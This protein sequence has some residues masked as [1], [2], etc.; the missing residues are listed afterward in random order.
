MHSDAIKPGQ[1]IR[2]LRQQKGLSQADLAKHLGVSKSLVSMVE[3]GTRRLSQEEADA[4]ASLLELPEDLIRLSMGHLPDDVERTLPQHA[5]LVTTAVRQAAEEYATR[6]GDGLDAKWRQRCVTTTEPRPEPLSAGFEGTIR[7]GKNST[8]YRAH[9][10]HTKVPP[11][12][13]VPLIE[14]YTSPG[15]IVLDPFGGSGMTGVAALRAGRHALLSDVSPAAVHISRNYVTPCDPAL[16][17]EA[18]ERLYRAVRST[19]NSLY[20]VVGSDG[21]RMTVEH[22]VWSDVYQCPSCREQWTFWEATA[23]EIGR[24]AAREIPCPRCR[25]GHAKR[26]LVWVREEPV[27]TSTSGVTGRKQDKH[28]PTAAELKL[29]AKAAAMPI[30]YWTPR[31]DF[32]RDR[33]M[34][35]ASHGVMGIRTVSDFYTPRNLHALAALRHFILQEPDVRLRDALLFA[36]TGCVNRASRRYQWNEKRPTNVMTGTLYISSLRYE[37]NVWSLFS[38]KLADVTRY[39]AGFPRTEAQ[40]EV[41]MASAT[42]L[43][44]VPDS[45]VDFVFMDPP[46]GS[47]IFYADS[48]LLWEG[49]LGR[50]TSLTD[51]IVVNQHV[52]TA[53]GG[54]TVT[55]Y[56][57]LLRQSFSEVHRVLKP[58]AR[59]VLAF[60]N[61][62]DKVWEAIR[63]AVEAAGFEVENAAVL[64][65][66]QHSIKG[67]QGSLGNERVTRLDLLLTLRGRVAETQRQ[68][69][70][71]PTRSQIV[72]LTT[73]C[74][75][76][77]APASV[78]TDH[79]YT[80]VVQTLLKDGASV[81]GVGMSEVEAALAEVAT[82]SRDGQWRRVRHTPAEPPT[83]G[84]PGS[85]Q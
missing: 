40:A 62:D 66:V 4:L 47:N 46:F 76:Q 34:W 79:V 63:I 31:A 60:S 51:E 45:S 48:S 83:G 70:P 61:T 71:A 84:G 85:L 55:R 7:A 20:D 39:Y 82:R 5:A 77:A 35:R 28:E 59:A 57:D 21:S 11:E 42:N 54:K 30:P 8:T 12:A 29:I 78:A 44:H 3:N 43:G 69:S 26:D 25:V 38:R 14:H 74:L 15:D 32:G 36:F 6:L 41:V 67:V 2:D 73:Q 65:K 23:Q 16:L 18:G 33:E 22:T 49:W 50:M 17:T 58:G 75:D 81:Q 53:D 68:A 19:M 27:A 72:D 9:S 24:E 10:Y 80:A 1:V 13:I 52:Q 56:S 64:D 37:W